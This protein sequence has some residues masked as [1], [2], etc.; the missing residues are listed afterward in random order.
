[1]SRAQLHIRCRQ[2][3]MTP[4]LSVYTTGFSCFSAEGRPLTGAASAPM[5]DPEPC[6]GAADVSS[7]DETSHVESS[8]DLVPSNSRSEP[9]GTLQT[10]STSIS[11]IG[12]SGSS[13]A[14]A[15]DLQGPAQV[16]PGWRGQLPGQKPAAPAAAGFAH[17]GSAGATSIGR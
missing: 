15:R 4:A 5:V 13:E 16:Q 17:L 14:S 9:P 11:T 7:A 1:M 6:A 8:S 10:T 3:Q 2:L 12:S